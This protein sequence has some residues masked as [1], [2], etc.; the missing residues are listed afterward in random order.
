VGVYAGVVVLDLHVPASTS[1]KAKRSVIKA[2]VM[3]LRQDLNCSVAETD[4]QDLWQRAELAVAIAGGSEVGVRKVAQQVEQIV[5]RE[6]RVEIIGV[7]VDVVVPE[8]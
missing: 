8:R 7:H 6:P 5:S 3:R 2:L 1:L 4:Y